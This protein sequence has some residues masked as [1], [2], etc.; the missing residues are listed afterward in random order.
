MSALNAKHF[1]D[2]NVAREYLEAIRWPTGPVCPHCGSIDKGHYALNGKAHR[3]GLWKCKDCRQQFSVTVG[4]VFEHSKVGLSKWLTAAYLMCSAKKGV[5]AHQLHRTL[6]VTYKTAWF[7]AH[8][9]RLAMDQPEGVFGSGGGVVEADKCY[10]GKVEGSP[11]RKELR[12]AQKAGQNPKFPKKVMVFALLDRGG[13]V[14]SRHIGGD[15]FDGIINA[16][17]DVSRDASLHTDDARLYW[18][19]GKHFASHETVNH[20]R[21]EYARG[22]VPPTPSKAS[23]Q[24]SSAA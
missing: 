2:D 8:R 7:M 5:S 4:T 24:C 20:S 6:G 16:L 18:N 17:K 3:P 23:S 1:H 19:I 9:I 22:H 13:K 21:G 15:M 12:A 14:R 11:T 10:I